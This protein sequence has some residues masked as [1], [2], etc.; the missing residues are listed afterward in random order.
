MKISCSHIGRRVLLM[1]AVCLLVS[2]SM[3]AYDFMV[4]GLCYNKNSDGKTVTV[5]YERTIQPYYTAL[6]GALTIPASV[7]NSGKTYSVTAIDANAFRGCT[8][9]T[10]VTVPNTVA[11][12][13]NYAF[14]GCNAIAKLTWNAANCAGFSFGSTHPFYAVTSVK[15]VVFGSTVTKIPNYLCADFINLTSIDWGTGVKDIGIGAFQGCTAL[16]AVTIPAQVNNVGHS[17][18]QGCSALKTVNWNAENCNN[19]WSGSPFSGCDIRSFVIGNNVKTITR[20]L[21]CYLSGLTSVT[22]PSSVTD[23]GEGAFCGC[24]GLTAM[25]VGSNVSVIGAE[26]FKDCTGLTAVTIPGATTRILNDAF[27]GCTNLTRVN[28]SDPA[29]W[30]NIT[31]NNSRSNPLYCAH[32]LYLN[33]SK[34]TDLVIPSTLSGVKAN[35]FYNCTSLNR[36]T[37]PNSVTSVA[38]SAF[39]GCTGLSQVDWDVP[40]CS[41]YA[42]K[43]FAPFDGLTNIK[44]F[45]LGNSVTKIPAF[46]C[47]GLS[48]LTTLSIPTTV[49][50]IGGGAFGDC[51]GLVRINNLATT[52]Q[53]IASSVFEGVD[54]PNCLLM[55]PQASLPA[56]KEANVWK[57]FLVGFRGDVNG[58]GAVTSS[59]IACIVNVLAGLDDTKQIKARADVNGEGE[60]TA[61]DVA[62]VVNILAGID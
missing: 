7:T 12:V 32:E 60:V 31:F 54:Q 53:P 17:V 45:L 48:G 36:V 20:R 11:S 46:L 40:A 27:M 10:A 19:G 35:T 52:P 61:A 14:Q 22:I 37:V 50:A 8:G 3:S 6:S 56:Y 58:D 30:C 21:C 43:S 49:T 42:V 5:T 33:G 62:D 34:V 15:S 28:I 18:F 23:I 39:R 4:G 47:Y 24:A 57:E 38:S 13:G 9:L 44:T 2:P 29:A 51:S 16:T 59:D 41:D 1:L 25:T 55:V 26:A